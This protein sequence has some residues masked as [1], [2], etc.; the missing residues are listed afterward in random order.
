MGQVRNLLR[1]YAIENSEPADVLRRTGIAL[2]RLLPEALATVVYAVLDPPPASSATPAPGTCR[3]SS[4][5]GPVTPS[6]STPRT[7]SCSAFPAAPP[8]PPDVGTWAPGAGILFYTDGLIEDRH[9]DITDGLD[10]LAAAMRNGLVR[11]AGQ[12]CVTAQA[13]L[14]GG[15]PAADDVCLLATWLTG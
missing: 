9:R 3:R 8:S 11:S 13:A 15:A 14:P 2:A 4:P 6:T 1:G 7:V 12:A 5:P 10:A